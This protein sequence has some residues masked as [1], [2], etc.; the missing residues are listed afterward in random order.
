MAEV[1]HIDSC[2][3]RGLIDPDDNQDNRSR[4]KRLLNS[5]HGGRFKISILAAGEVLGKIAETKSVSSAAEAAAELS[6]MFRRRKL[7]LYGIGR[8]EAAM[9]LAV[10]LMRGDPMITP[11]DALL[12]ACA[13]EDSECSV[14]AT[15][16]DT[17]IESRYIGMYAISH[18]PKILDARANH[19]KINTSRLGREVNMCLRHASS[20]SLLKVEAD[21]C[22]YD[23]MQ[24]GVSRTSEKESV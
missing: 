4:A 21:G 2:L 17:L 13:F 3:L 23:L 6:R 14:F 1:I 19:R 18:G 9:A 11:S 22:R 10:E 16:D 8:R 12:V 20:A 24:R 5:S 15:S 7:S